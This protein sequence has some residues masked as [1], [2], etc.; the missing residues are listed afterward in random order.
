MMDHGE[1]A[2][3]S[4]LL[5]GFGSISVLPF[6]FLRLFV[7][8]GF[9]VGIV[10]LFI[11]PFIVVAFFVY[12]LK[13][14][15][16]LHKIEK[17]I[18]VFIFAIALFT[19][20]ASNGN[21]GLAFLVKSLFYALYFRLLYLMLA[22]MS[23]D[24]RFRYLR[25]AVSIGLI[26][27]VVHFALG[28]GIA[29]FDFP[30]EPTIECLIDDSSKTYVRPDKV[31]GGQLK[32]IV[33]GLTVPAL[34]AFDEIWPVKLICRSS[35]IGLNALAGVF[36]LYLN[37]ILL[38]STRGGWI[39]HLLLASSAG[40]LVVMDSMGTLVALAAIMMWMCFNQLSLGQKFVRH[41]FRMSLVSGFV[42]LFLAVVSIG[43]GILDSNHEVGRIAQYKLSIAQILDSPISG[44]G[45]GTK[46]AHRD[47]SVYPHNFILA[48]WLMMGLVGLVA[49]FNLFGFLV[50]QTIISMLHAM[51]DET[52]DRIR[53]IL[54]IFLIAPV[55]TLLIRSSIESIFMLS[56]WISMAVFLSCYSSLE[57]KEV[58]MELKR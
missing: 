11:L 6:L 1:I 25:I 39:K 7:V 50:Y 53:R 36:L 17:S 9:Q 15:A 23:Y 51:A 40:L 30:V 8:Q 37:I 48:S 20:F 22:S 31:P 57:K 41:F 54:P 32:S 2:R 10:H 47:H 21:G 42:L 12:G 56:D 38:T 34:A 28:Y 5:F 18:L 45:L 35:D 46:I 24:K 58:G 29:K 13:P 14:G 55:V 43:P 16:P 4:A 52:R 33:Y 26:L 19:F 3:K 44:K 27:F 49:A